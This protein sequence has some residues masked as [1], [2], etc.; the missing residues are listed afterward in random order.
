ME[1]LEVTARTVNEAIEK[2]LARLHLTRDEVDVSVLS[3]GSR[4]IFGIGGEDA[5]ILVSPRARLDQE[6]VQKVDVEVAASKVNGQEIARI[7]RD[8]LENLLDGLGIVAD[9]EVRPVAPKAPNGPGNDF[10]AVLDI[11][12]DDL[13][14]LI[15]RRGDT[16]AALQF[17]TNLILAR[18][19]RRS[20]KVQVDVEGYRVRREQTLQ[21]LATRVAERVAATGEPISLEAMPPNERRIVH[22][23]LQSHPQVM[24]AST[25]EGD[26]R[27]VVV[28]PRR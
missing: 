15:G 13:G 28:H 25:G 5:R 7:A 3:E 19:T 24:T 16:L 26:Q 18:R 8:I 14:I 10:S 9:V 6:Q 12:G 20:A 1:S 4:G 11:T 21:T 27:R 17:L 23:T 2:A 22:V